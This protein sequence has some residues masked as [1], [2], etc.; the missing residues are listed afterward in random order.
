MVRPNW[1]LEATIGTRL[2]VSHLGF[3]IHTPVGIMFR[4]ASSTQKRVVET[5]L[6]DY[7]HDCLDN[8]T[9]KGINIQLV[10]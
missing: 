10:E 3:V 1:D 8:P 4:H 5:S 7:L 2:D 6:L 9:I